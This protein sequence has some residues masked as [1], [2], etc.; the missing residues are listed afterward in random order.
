[1]IP[2]TNRTDASHVLYLLPVWIFVV[3]LSG[4]S[5]DRPSALTEVSVN[6]RE[7]V[8]MPGT[9]EPRLRST[10]NVIAPSRII[11][12]LEKFR[13][14]NPKATMDELADFGNM[15]LP[16]EGFNFFIDL[17]KAVAG[18]IERKE[19]VPSNGDGPGYSVTFKLNFDLVGGGTKV[20]S[21][22]AP[23]E[24]V[25]CCGFHYTPFPV[26]SITKD[27][28]TVVVGGEQLEIKR[29]EF[30]PV[31]LENTLFEN[32]T[33]IRSWQTPYEGRPYGISDDGRKLYFSV[34]SFDGLLL[35]IN[36]KGSIRFV[37]KTTGSILSE[38]KDINQRPAPK[39]GEIL[40]KSG[41]YG[42][43]E[44]NTFGITLYVEFP[45]VCS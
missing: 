41:E 33:K 26:T 29:D 17:E 22:T 5:V 40:Y 15:L 11:E 9:P 21:I 25:C 14:E 4:C 20:M 2:E 30:L 34:K 35:E 36:E 19:A 37:P 38:G 1:M 3:F 42:L 13:S 12:K 24:P 27:R 45:Y 28:M 8:Q 32:S 6:D 7:I 31:D 18:A 23:A 16:T 43:M 39:V 44:Y 10:E